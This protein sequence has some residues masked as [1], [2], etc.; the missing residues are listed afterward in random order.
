MVTCGASRDRVHEYTGEV[1]GET[2]RTNFQAYLQAGGSCVAVHKAVA[3]N[4]N[5]LVRQDG[6]PH[7]RIHPQIQTA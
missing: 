4:K 6:R 5:A 3:T 2:Q 1:L 7:F